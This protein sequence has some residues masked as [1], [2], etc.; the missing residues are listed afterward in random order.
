MENFYLS[1]YLLAMS[2]ALINPTVYYCM[3]RCTSHSSVKKIKAR[4]G[5][6][7]LFLAGCRIIRHASP[8]FAA[9]SCLMPD[10]RPD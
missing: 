6:D 5:P 8:V 1:I 3:N 4:V 10:I 7:L 9:M 2:T